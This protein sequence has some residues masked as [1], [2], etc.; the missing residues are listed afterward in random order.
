[1]RRASG[2]AI[3]RSIFGLSGEGAGAPAYRIRKAKA[4]ARGEG[5]KLVAW[6]VLAQ[7]GQPVGANRP[8]QRLYQAARRETAPEI[9]IL[10]NQFQDPPISKQHNA[11]QART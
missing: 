11:G 7:G 2:E 9:L 4:P 8:T 6:V 3:R 1:M 5:K 10:V